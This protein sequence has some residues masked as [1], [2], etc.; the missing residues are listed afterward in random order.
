MKKITEPSYKGCDGFTTKS[1]SGRLVVDFP[2]TKMW[3]KIPTDRQ[4]KTPTDK[5]DRQIYHMKVYI[6]SKLR[7]T[8]RDRQAL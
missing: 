5:A 7:D 4:T 3:A 6:S 1:I 8:Q 2:S